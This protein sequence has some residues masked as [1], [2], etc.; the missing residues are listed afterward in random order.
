MSITGRGLGGAVSAREDRLFLVW[1]LGMVREGFM[2][3]GTLGAG[4]DVRGL[5]QSPKL[6]LEA[7]G[8]HRQWPVGGLEGLCG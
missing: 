2:E 4:P 5:T 8:S 7:V 1:V 3:E 6:C